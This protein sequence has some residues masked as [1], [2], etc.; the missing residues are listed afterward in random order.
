MEMLLL[1]SSRVAGHGY[2]DAYQGELASFLG[3]RSRAAFLPFAGVTLGWDEY[4]AL[5][6]ER[7]ARLGCAVEGLHR[8]AD[9]VAAIAAAEVVIVGGGNSFN[10][11]KEV[12]ERGL[13]APIRARIRQGGRYLGWSAGANLACP[14]IRTT[15]DM[16]IVEPP[17]L[18]ALGLVTFQINP[19]YTDAVAPGHMGE[20]RDQR[21]AEFLV[22][23]PGVPVLGLREGS[24]VHGRDGRLRLTG[25]L[26]AKL[27]RQ[28]VP[29]AEIAPGPFEL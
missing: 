21:L 6:A 25:T 9:P 1:S 14:T 4:T 22:A 15:N 7:L 17:T 27:F 19:H 12:H 2:L 26:P 24:A 23:N 16:P 5:V 10:L 13:V 8:A 3:G 18:D 28:G 20:T 29:A 11:L